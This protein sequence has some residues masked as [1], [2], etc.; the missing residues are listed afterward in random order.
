[1]TKIETLSFLHS[2]SEGFATVLQQLLGTQTNRIPDT[3]THVTKID[4]EHS[5]RIPLLYT[6]YLAHTSA[7]SVGG[8]KNI[9]PVNTKETLQLLQ[10][11]DCP[12]LHEPSAPKH[13]TETTQGQVDFLVIPEVLNGS[14]D[15]FVGVLGEGI[16]SLRSETVPSI[17]KT[18]FPGWVDR[19]LSSYIGDAIA[20]VILDKAVF[21]AYIIQNP[22]STAAR[23]AGV[24]ESDVLSPQEARY[25]AISADSHLDSEV[26]YIE[27]SGSYDEEDATSIIEAIESSLN[28]SRLW[29][30]G[31]LN[32]RE[33]VRTI[34]EAGADAVVVGNVFHEIAEHEV[35]L[36][37][38]LR[39]DRPSVEGL[40]R[41]E[42]EN[43][44]MDAVEITRTAGARY[45][46]TT[47][48]ES[49]ADIAKRVLTDTLFIYSY[50][51]YILSEFPNRSPLEQ[52][53][54]LLSECSCAERILN[55]NGQQYL[56]EIFTQYQSRT[57]DEISVS[58]IRHISKPNQY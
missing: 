45:L 20:A 47:S 21:E 14:S 16:E 7:I 53:E 5:R 36:Y 43:W 15:A 18:K 52:R 11:V 4:P 12:V 32:S 50:I 26:V 6:Q 54:I 56:D 17:L 1:M 51:D 41:D 25:Y 40:S 23:K 55:P 24:S 10:R 13:V 19:K 22:D 35:S 2:L 57:S 27:Y 28:W 49:Y 48:S 46:S 44:I 31:G 30:G 8:S 58:S 9:T 38:T 34:T 29:Y 37:E 33:Q 39:T 3:W 42:V